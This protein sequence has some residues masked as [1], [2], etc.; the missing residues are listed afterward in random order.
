MGTPTFAALRI[1][2]EREP[3]DELP[4]ATLR[5]WSLAMPTTT[6]TH[7]GDADSEEGGLL[8]LLGALSALSV[9]ASVANPVVLATWSDTECGTIPFLDMRVASFVSDADLRECIDAWPWRL[10][11]NPERSTEKRPGYTVDFPLYQN[12]WHMDVEWVARPW[13][14]ENGVPCSLVEVMTEWGMVVPGLGDRLMPDGG[15]DW[16]LSAVAHAESQGVRLLAGALTAG[17]PE[18]HQVDPRLM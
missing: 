14:E 9:R 4:Q 1:I 15:N 8:A 12:V 3:G 6:L 5:A 7:V 18:S 13:C 16:A 10:H 2:A 17:V 11:L